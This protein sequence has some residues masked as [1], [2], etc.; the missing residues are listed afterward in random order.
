MAD[1]YADRFERNYRQGTDVWAVYEHLAELYTSAVREIS[2][3]QQASYSAD[4]GNGNE[5]RRDAFD[6][7]VLAVQERQLKPWFL[8]AHIDGGRDIGG[9]HFVQEIQVRIMVHIRFKLIAVAIESPT[10]VITNGLIHVGKPYL[11]G[12]LP[13]AGSGRLERTLSTRWA[14][15]IGAIAIAV[16]A[17]G[18]AKLV[19]WV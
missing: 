3:A 18:I 17:A 11:N 2:A 14:K 5:P 10:K 16:V 9:G 12:Q 19:G 4:D 1:P 8:W 13:R 15:G 6:D 7:L